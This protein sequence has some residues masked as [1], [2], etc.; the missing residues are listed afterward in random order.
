[1]KLEDDVTVEAPTVTVIGP[2]VAPP[3]TVMLTLFS[4]AAVTVANVPLILTVLPL[5]AVLKFCPWMVTVVPIP[6]CWGVKFRMASAFG[7][8]R[9]ERDIESRLPTAS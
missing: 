8:G 3:G 7:E 2:V 6:P 1:M 5:G 9:A 4:V